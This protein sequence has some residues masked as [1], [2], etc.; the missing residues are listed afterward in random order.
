MNVFIDAHFLD[1]K[2]EGNRTFVLSLLSGIKKLVENNRDIAFYLPV[3][4]REHWENT[5]GSDHFH[6]LN[7]SRGS[8]KRYLVDFPEIIKKYHIDLVQ[9]TFH[10]PLWMN[11]NIKKVL[12]LH[13]LLPFSRPE[14]FAA[15]FRLR[16]KKM[17]RLSARAADWIVCGSRFTR[18]E[19]L[20]HLP[21]VAAKTMIVPYGIDLEV[22]TALPAL[23]EKYAYLGRIERPFVLFVGRLDQRKNISFLLDVQEKLFEKWGLQLVVAGKKENIGREQTFRLKKM[24]QK[25]KVVYTGEIPDDAL[26]F[27]YRKAN[28]LLYF[29]EAEGFG[30]PVIEAMKFGLPYL[31]VSC[32]ALKD[33]AIPEAVVDINDQDEVIKKAGDLVK[34][35]R[36][37]R[38]FIKKS[39]ENLKKFSHMAMAS[40]M[41]T[42][43]RDLMKNSPV[44]SEQPK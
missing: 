44:E 34:N 16:F 28:L 20:R 21:F 40:N 33:T 15:G 26:E 32:G 10:F 43:Y 9:T 14:L 25:K 7:C 29:P 18:L 37:R 30:F 38:D 39:R 3:F 41:L 31:T 23:S 36:I 13:D 6:W 1:K 8:V 35:Q 42:I 24:V 22:N 4:C 11:K 5:L 17:V 2:K 19:I 27:L 12:I